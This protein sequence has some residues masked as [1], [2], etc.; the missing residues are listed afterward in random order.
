MQQC[1][2]TSNAKQRSLG[3][4]WSVESARAGIMP[5]PQ[6]RPDLLG[7]GN[8][9]AAK[10]VHT[11]DLLCVPPRRLASLRGVPHLLWV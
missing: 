4:A 3:E 10:V 2:E 6:Q 1:G 7:S 11:S 5:A 8:S 9:V